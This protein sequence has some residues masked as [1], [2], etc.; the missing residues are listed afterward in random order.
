MFEIRRD[1]EEE[2]IELNWRR[3]LKDESSY[4]QKNREKKQK[5]SV[6]F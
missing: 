3:E 1:K 5:Y 4:Y 6:K 2:D